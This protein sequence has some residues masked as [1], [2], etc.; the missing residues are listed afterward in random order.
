M[1]IEEFFIILNIFAALIIVVCNVLSLH[2]LVGISKELHEIN[3][4]NKMWQ[5]FIVMSSL[6][7]MLGIIEATGTIESVIYS[8][9]Q[10]FFDALMSMVLILFFVFSVLLAMSIEELED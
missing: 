5:L 9:F 4:I 6:F 2:L 10:S 3:N 8:T 7:I 1:M